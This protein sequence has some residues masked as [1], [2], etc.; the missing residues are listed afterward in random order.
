M[1]RDID[2]AAATRDLLSE[3][4]PGVELVV[5]AKTRSPAEVMEAINGGAKNIGENYLDE[6][7]RAFEV[8]GKKACWH[9]I[10]RLQKN[11]I[12]RIVE[13]FDLIETLDSI[14]MARLIEASCT[15]IGKVM[16]VLVEINIGREPQKSGIMPEEAPGFIQEAAGFRHLRVSGLMTMG[17]QNLSQ[18]ELRPY[19]TATRRLFGE[20]GQSGIARVEMRYLSMGMTDSYRAA[21]EEG[22]NVVRIGSKI[23]G[24]R[25]G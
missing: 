3:L 7:E 8:I 13:L 10:G 20:I 17:P 6:A 21:I 9:F 1:N 23:F 12:G 22:A 2:I 19:F 15:A 5:A 16:P 11:K 24:P 14:D 4:T 18:G 25:S